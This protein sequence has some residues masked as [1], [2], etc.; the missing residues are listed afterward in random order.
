MND[1]TA[2]YSLLKNLKRGTIDGFLLDKHTYR[3]FKQYVLPHIED[4][5]LVEFFLKGTM[6]TNIPHLG[7]DMMSY[8]V[9]IKYERR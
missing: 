9:L 6:L 4:R 2:F 7:E 8:G 5:K 1:T 3:Y